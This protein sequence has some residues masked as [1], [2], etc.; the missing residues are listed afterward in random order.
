[1]TRGTYSKW[2]LRE[3][4][5]AGAG[6]V[7]APGIELMSV[8]SLSDIRDGLTHVDV[9]AFLDLITLRLNIQSVDEIG[10]AI[11]LFSRFSL[12]VY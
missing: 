1:M 6:G 4:A 3:G 5:G 7:T 8:P 10:K 11:Y 9:G 2:I 12:S